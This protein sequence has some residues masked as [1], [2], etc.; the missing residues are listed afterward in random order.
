MSIS[1]QDVDN[2]VAAAGDE[3]EVLIAHLKY[4]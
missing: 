4:F 1:I 2:F 3:L